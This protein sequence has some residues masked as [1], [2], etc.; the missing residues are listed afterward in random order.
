MYPLSAVRQGQITDGTSKTFLVGECSWDFGNEVGPWYVGA[1]E[2]AGD[3]DTPAEL[4]YAA[5]R[6]GGGFW[7]YNAAQIRWG[8]TERSN[9]GNPS[10]RTTPDKACHSDLSFGSKHPGGCH[11]CLA[12][13]SARFV[14]SDVDVMVL[15]YFAC[16]HD[17][18]SADLD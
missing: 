12:D 3:Y 6:I 8:L 13:G 14:K 18:F 15:R 10:E 11:F 1:G 5:S 7:I 2:W 4:E 9:D 16:R 17:G